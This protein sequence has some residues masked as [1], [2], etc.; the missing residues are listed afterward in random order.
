LDYVEDVTPGSGGLGVNTATFGIGP[1]GSTDVS[2]YTGSTFTYPTSFGPGG[3]GPSS[4]LGSGDYFGIF[5]GI[6]PER[7][8]VVPTG[9]V[10][11]SYIAGSLTLGGS[12]FLS[13]GMSA[14]TYNYSWGAGSGQ[15]FVLTIG[16][17][18]PTPTPTPTPTLTPTPTMTLTP[19]ST[20]TNY[21]L[22]QDGFYLLQEDGSKIIIT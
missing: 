11:G 1:S 12:S 21:L 17:I 2:L 8:L 15:S 6:L 7:A 20:D 14:G 22:Q 10:S 5:T 18:S 3:G 16:G 4:V 19:T 9:Y 13:L